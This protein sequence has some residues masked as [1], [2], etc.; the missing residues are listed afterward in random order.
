[1]AGRS[2]N[3]ALSGSFFEQIAAKLAVEGNLTSM[4]PSRRNLDNN[5]VEDM[6]E[7]RLE[8]ISLENLVAYLYE[9]EKTGAAIAISN[10]NIAIQLITVDDEDIPSWRRWV[11][12]VNTNL[13]D[14]EEKMKIWENLTKTMDAAIRNFSKKLNTTDRRKFNKIKNDIYVEMNLSE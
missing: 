11:L 7:V 5:L 3:F 2:G 6:V 12:I 9:I 8:G 14:L 1:M 13:S 10:I 4:K